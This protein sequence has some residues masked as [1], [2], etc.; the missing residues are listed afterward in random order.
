MSRKLENGTTKPRAGKAEQDVSGAEVPPVGA[1]GKGR[2]KAV[3]L[4]PRSNGENDWQDELP[5]NDG[6]PA[7]RR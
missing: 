6:R 3:D 2:I 1:V 4:E 5:E 7:D